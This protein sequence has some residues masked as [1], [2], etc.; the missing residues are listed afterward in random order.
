MTGALFMTLLA[1]DTTPATTSAPADWMTG[2]PIGTFAG[3]TAA[4]M[5]ISNVVAVVRKKTTIYVPLGLSLLFALVGTI[6]TFTSG[7]F[8]SKGV[9]VLVNWAMLF[10]AAT[11]TNEMAGRGGGGGGGGA[12][13]AAAPPRRV[14]NSWLG[15]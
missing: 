7:N 3:A 8:L 9:L 4:V 1:A 10:S 14:F 6:P 5:I 12:A 15:P 2:E 11:G 13:A